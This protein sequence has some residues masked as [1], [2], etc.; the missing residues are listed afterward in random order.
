[1]GTRT[2]TASEQIYISSEGRMVYPGEQFTVSDEVKP[3]KTWLD[4][5]GEPL[6]ADPLDHD[7]DGKKGGS[8]PRSNQADA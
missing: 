3:G 1:M 6:P 8:R 2:F 7:G 5:K 4:E